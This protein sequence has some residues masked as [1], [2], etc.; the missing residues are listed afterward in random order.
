MRDIQTQANAAHGFS[1][2]LTSTLTQQTDES[3]EFSTQLLPVLDVYLAELNRKIDG[4]PD[5]PGWRNLITV[6]SMLATLIRDELFE[7]NPGLEDYRPED[8]PQTV[9]EMISRL[10]SDALELFTSAQAKSLA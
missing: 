9:P 10:L 6:V 2:W 3:R 7:I 1:L 5:T 8:E 4:D